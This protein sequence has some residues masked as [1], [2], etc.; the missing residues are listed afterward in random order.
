MCYHVLKG[1]T[2]DMVLCTVQHICCMDELIA[3]SSHPQL[4]LR[5]AQHYLPPAHKDNSECLHC[6]H[7]AHLDEYDVCARV[8]RVPVPLL[9][10]AGHGGE[11]QL[12]FGSEDHVLGPDLQD[13]RRL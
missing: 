11:V 4:S 12:V 5:V 9:R 8:R 10:I 7:G 3:R 2:S 1:L 6:I 13:G